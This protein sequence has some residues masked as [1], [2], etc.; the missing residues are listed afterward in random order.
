LK[1]KYD[2]TGYYSEQIASILKILDAEKELGFNQLKKAVIQDDKDRAISRSFSPGQLSLILKALGE[3]KI[4]K[5]RPTG[6]MTPGHKR[7]YSL[8]T[9]GQ[10]FVEQ[11][12]NAF[13]TRHFEKFLI[14][15]HK[16]CFLA[17]HGT[18]HSVIRE[19]SAVPGDFQLPDEPYCRYI[20]TRD[21]VS[22]QDV[23]HDSNI[24]VEVSF[25]NAKFTENELT[26]YFDFLISNGI[27]EHKYTDS[28]CRRRY[29]ICALYKDMYRMLFE[30]FDS[31]Y[32]ALSV[33]LGYVKGLTPEERKWFEQYMG[34]RKSD[35]YLIRH[36][37][38]RKEIFSTSQ[39]TKTPNGKPNR[40]QPKYKSLYED[41]INSIYCKIASKYSGYLKDIENG[42]DV[43]SSLA[44]LLFHFVTFGIIKSEKQLVQ[45]SLT[46]EII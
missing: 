24:E 6:I 5:I 27:I 39:K 44:D 42:Q 21:G 26:R 36:Y 38:N 34:K 28:E 22:F 1:F 20:E 31:I 46:R 14:I 25:P 37:Y 45:K 15:C 13:D 10:F 12:Y 7:L 35:L 18:Q 23:F 8:T 16:I 2:D 11:G 9:I 43:A 17:I 4:V 40:K 33:K 41:H 3:R 30:L 19:G 32:T 29:T